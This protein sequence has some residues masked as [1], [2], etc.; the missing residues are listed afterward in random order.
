MVHLLMQVVPPTLVQEAHLLDEN[1]SNDLGY[2]CCDKCH[3]FY[4]LLIMVK[5]KPIEIDGIFKFIVVVDHFFERTS[6]E[7]FKQEV[8]EVNYL[9]LT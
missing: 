6:L 7:E 3:F 2:Q 1:Q 5:L 9:L 4:S 8:E